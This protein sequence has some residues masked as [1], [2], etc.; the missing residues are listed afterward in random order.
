MFLAYIP[1]ISFINNRIHHLVFKFIL[2]FIIN[3]LGLFFKFNL[4]LINLINNL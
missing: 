4:I 2:L 3:F 1:T